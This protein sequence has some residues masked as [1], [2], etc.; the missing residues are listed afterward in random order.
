MTHRITILILFLIIVLISDTSYIYSNA[1]NDEAIRS[2]IEYKLETIKDGEDTKTRNYYIKQEIFV[3]KFYEATNFKPAWQKEKIDELIKSI[4]DIKKDGLKPEDYHL[5]IIIDL[6]NAKYSRKVF[7]P[8]TAADLDILLTDALALLLDHLENG[9]LNPKK[10]YSNWNI[11]KESDNRNYDLI[12]SKALDSNNLYDFIEEKKPQ[13]AYYKN[14]K[15]ALNKF[16]FLKN[17]NSWKSI[18]KGKLLKQ[19]MYDKRVPLIKDRL[20][21]T[22][23]LLDVSKIGSNYYDPTLVEAIKEFQLHYNLNPDGT[24]GPNTLYEL[25]VS[26]RDRIDQIKVNLE[27]AR[28]VL[29][30]SLN[31]FLIVNIAGYKA[32]YAVDNEVLWSSKLVVGK[33]YRKTPVFKSEIKHIVFNP[34]WS[35]PSGIFRKDILP[36]VKRNPY[37]LTS[38]GFNIYNTSGTRVSP[39]SINWAQYSGNVP[40]SIRQKPG[41]GNALGRVKFIFPNEY[42]VYLHDT[43]KK[44]LFKKDIKTFS[45]GCIR[46]EKPFELAELLLNDK[47]KWNIQTINKVVNKRRTRTVF[48][49]EPIS[50]IIMY[51]TASTDNIGNVY[52]MKDI[53]GR[54]KEVLNRL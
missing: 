51:W 9:K 37:Y 47:E 50:I 19:G 35:V 23:H 1:Y 15:R 6:V 38:R 11:Q 29:N 12:I 40:Y 18:P 43:P 21:A 53:Y 36:I 45:S 30:S 42:A 4:I 34:T 2:I 27:R 16:I 8:E 33:T 28:W 13:I 22:N 46:I 5:K 31:K 7:F 25:N 17:K 41:P 26:V 54:D 49:K 39:S 32:Y 44:H 52:F 10:I 14:L 48:L 20:I 24:I 3:R